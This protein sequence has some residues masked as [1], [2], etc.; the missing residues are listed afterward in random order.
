[1]NAATTNGKIEPLLCRGVLSRSGPDRA[2]VCTREC[3]GVMSLRWFIY[4]CAIVGGWSAG[5]GWLIGRLIEPSSELLKASL[6]GLFLGMAVALG[7]GL[8]DTLWNLSI[9]RF[10]EVFLRVG[11]TFLLG[12]LGGFLGGLIGQLFYELTEAAAFLVLGWTLTGALIGGSIGLFEWITTRGA[13]GKFLKSLIGG[14]I[15]GIIGGIFYLLLRTMFENIFVKSLH[16]GIDL[17][18]PSGWGFIILGACIGLLVGLAQVILKEAWIKVEAG[19]RPGREMMLVK[20]R[21][22]IGRA[23]ASDLGLFGDMGIEKTHAYIV[24][25][26][27][28]YY[29]EDADTPGGTYVNDERV[30]DRMPL[31]AGDLIRIGKALVRFHERQKRP[32]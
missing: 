12:T 2:G 31:R 23:E 22:S 17:L 32:K 30:N 3:V 7:L 27:N 8:L 6:R 18:S 11:T 28:R 5:I 25:K 15:G 13:R 4:F 29:L 19:F 24:Q 14:T 10:G 26:G 20:D 16:F 21:F 9:R 1:M